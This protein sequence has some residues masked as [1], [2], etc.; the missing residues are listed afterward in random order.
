MEDRI[1]REGERV[2]ITGISR[3][4]WWA[5]E[6]AGR[7]P[8]RRQIGASSVGWL[9]SELQSWLASREVG[10]AASPAKALAARDQRKGVPGGA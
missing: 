6:K 7:C 2:R 1:V 8:M 4:A 3:S 5:G 9:L 10:P